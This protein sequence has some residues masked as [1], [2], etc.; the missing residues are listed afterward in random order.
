M[1]QHRLLPRR[2]P[3]GNA[4]DGPPTISIVL[5]TFN[6]ARVLEPQL[7]S[8]SDQTLKPFEVIVRDDGSS[9]DTLEIVR[10]FQR[11]SGLNVELI[12]GQNVG[13]PDSFLL[14]AGCAAG[15]YIAFC[16][17]DAVWRSDKLEV[18]STLL[19]RYNP[20]LLAHGSEVVDSTGKPFPP[21]LI[22]PARHRKLLQRWRLPSH[23][24][25]LG[26]CVL[27]H[28]DLVLPLAA[29]ASVCPIREQSWKDGH[30]TIVCRLANY[31]GGLLLTP[32]ST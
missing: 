30:D 31:V 29:L 26:C 2:T 9:D 4:I 5:S 15:D 17:Q 16:D 14:A 28:R 8:L 10:S 19:Q 7:Q 13:F 6:G 27:A 25:H 21:Y 23:W 3:Q 32:D 20:L 22:R 18:C 24:L 1:T 12:E 11:S